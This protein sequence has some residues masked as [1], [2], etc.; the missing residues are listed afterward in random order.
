MQAGGFL[1]G[2][3][4]A[5]RRQAA[6]PGLGDRHQPL[7]GCLLRN[8]AALSPEGLLSPQAELTLSHGSRWGAALLVRRKAG[9]APP[10]D[11]LGAALHF[12]SGERSLTEDRL[13]TAG[14]HCPSVRWGG[15]RRD[16]G[17]LGGTV[18]AANL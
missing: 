14:F 13:Q 3:V 1:G 8:G 17:E 11:D 5:A 10:P 7:V 18:L 15:P 16:G 6:R 4:G 2:D 9:T 12:V